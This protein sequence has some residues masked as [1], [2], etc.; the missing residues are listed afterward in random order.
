MPHILRLVKELVKRASSAQA[1]KANNRSVDIFKVVDPDA[2]VKITL[3]RFRMGSPGHM[4]ADP[5]IK[6]CVHYAVP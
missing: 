4:H 3:S 5:M 6:S 1:S 2:D